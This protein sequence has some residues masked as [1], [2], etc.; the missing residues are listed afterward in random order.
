M[1]SRAK[2]QKSSPVS[3]SIA[4]ETS[5]ILREIISKTSNYKEHANFLVELEPLFLESF[6]GART[7]FQRLVML[8]MDVHVPA[9]LYQAKQPDKPRIV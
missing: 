6:Q 8:R 3:C 2:Q 4:E 1:Q 9:D 5:P 7:Q